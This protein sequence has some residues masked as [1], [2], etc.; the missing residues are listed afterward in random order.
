M[1]TKTHVYDK[2]NALL[3]KANLFFFFLFSLL[4]SSSFGLGV[5]LRLYSQDLEEE[6]ISAG[7]ST[8]GS[9]Y[10][11]ETRS[12]FSRSDSVLESDSSDS[13]LDCNLSK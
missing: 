4:L 6:S 13:E 1:G 11:E 7:T 2:N 3:V 10:V 5:L 12:S 9:T 8:P